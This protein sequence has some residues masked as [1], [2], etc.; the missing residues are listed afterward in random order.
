MGGR[1]TGR[2]ATGAAALWVVIALVAS[3][4]GAGDSDDADTSTTVPAPETTG[5]APETSAAPESTDVGEPATVVTE[6]TAAPETTAPATTAEAASGETACSPAQAPDGGEYAVTNIPADDPDGGL[7]AR[8]LPG[9]AGERIDV[10]P[11]GTVVDSD[12][13]RPGCVVTADG[14]VWWA[15]D[16]PTLATGGWVN[17]RFLGPVGSG[18]GD[19]SDDGG[20]EDDFDIALAQL[21]CVYRGNEESCD[22]LVTFGIGTADDN[23]GLGNSYSQAPD[24]AIVE[25]CTVDADAIACAE[26]ELRGLVLGG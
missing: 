3:A 26:G 18:G 17:S 7:V 19:G 24:D 4:C 13:E 20:G 1:R 11:E 8:L 22:L 25:L 21:D 6:T 12:A 16:T 10:L 9:T 14:G 23:H 15:I 2:T 5:V